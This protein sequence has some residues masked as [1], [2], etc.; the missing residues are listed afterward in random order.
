MNNDNLVDFVASYEP[1][2]RVNSPSEKVLAAMRRVDRRSFVPPYSGSLPWEVELVVQ[3][4]LRDQYHLDPESVPLKEI[5][6]L[7]V[8]LP[9]GYDQT[10][11]QPSVVA[12][13]A[14]LLQLEPGMRVLEVGTGCGYNAA[15]LAEIVGPSGQVISIERIAPL[16]DVARQNLSA[17]FGRE[18]EQR[19]TVVHGDGSLGHMERAPYERVVFT[20]GIQRER[21][22][23]T[24]IIEQCSTGIHIYSQHM[25]PLVVE[26]YREGKMKR[27]DFLGNFGFV[28]LKRGIDPGYYFT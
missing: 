27:Q 28:P 21:F 12:L 19:V 10:C 14:S 6:Y 9:I 3:G 16:V 7:N 18:Y 22:D 20:A 13:M 1:L 23:I 2:L 4:L 11:S 5:P 17:H 25:G 24:T 8:A 26:K 15:I